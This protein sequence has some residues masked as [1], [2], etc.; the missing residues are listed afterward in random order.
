MI[1]ATTSVASHASHQRRVALLGVTPIIATGQTHNRTGALQDRRCVDAS[2]HPTVLS[3]VPHVT[4]HASVDELGIAGHVGG[5]LDIR[6]G[7]AD[8]I[9]AERVRMAG[10][11]VGVVHG[12]TVS[13]RVALNSRFG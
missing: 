8:R 6:A 5:Q 13:Y 9:E 10:D 4:V 1:I 11:G 7:K 2:P 3:Q 12:R